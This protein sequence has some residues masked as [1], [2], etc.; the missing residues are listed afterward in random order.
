MDFYVMEHLVAAFQEAKERKA[1]YVAIKVRMDGFPEDE[2]I[3]NKYANIDSKLEYYKKTYDED[4][5]HKFSKGIKI[6]DFTY[7]NRFEY[8]ELDFS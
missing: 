5:N 7:S 3:I 1:S 2:I 6:I 8:I 4:L